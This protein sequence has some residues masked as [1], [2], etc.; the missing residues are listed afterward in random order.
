VGA[1]VGLRGVVTLIRDLGLRE[2][3]R[4]QGELVDGEID[5]DVERYLTVS[6]QVDS[7]LVADVVLD[8][9][10]GVR[11]AA[12]VLV[13]ALPVADGETVGDTIEAVRAAMRTHVVHR[14]LAS[15]RADHMDAAML[16]AAVV[17]EGVASILEAHAVRFHCPCDADRV[18]GALATLGPA[19]LEALVEEQGEAQVICEFCNELYTLTADEVRTFAARLRS[20]LN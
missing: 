11:A 6:E 4:G 13:Q 2:N 10:G 8:S 16:V 7:A 12:A 1:L 17:P 19:D 20:A 18:R 14:L 9:S 15:A 5:S 3:Y